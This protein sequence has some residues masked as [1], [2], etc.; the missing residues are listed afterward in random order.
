MPV[1]NP[2]QYV[3]V[4]RNDKLRNGFKITTLSLDE[5]VVTKMQPA[6][7]NI[8]SNESYTMLPLC[9]T[10]YLKNSLKGWLALS[11][12]AYPLLIKQSYS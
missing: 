7:E 9:C 12:G 6:G 1:E 2:V 10:C 11:N 3:S 5:S 8:P 4:D